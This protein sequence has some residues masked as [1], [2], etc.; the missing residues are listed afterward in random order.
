VSRAPRVALAAQLD[1]LGVGA[2]DRLLTID[3]AGFKYFTGRGGV[4]TPDDPID[5]IESV[6]R[7][8]GTRWLVLERDDLARAL[9]PVL[10]GE[11]RPA[12][13]GPQ[14]YSVPAADGGP[15]RLAFYAVCV[16]AADAR[17]SALA[18]SAG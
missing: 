1:R 5:T 12:W 15:P 18:V 9:I 7:A 14:L 8:Y 17:C 2:G 16:E 10:R 11:A 4:V 6:A 13:I 3:A